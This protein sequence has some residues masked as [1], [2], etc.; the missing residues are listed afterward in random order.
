MQQLLSY[1]L[2]GACVIRLLPLTVEFATSKMVPLTAAERK[3]LNFKLSLN[4]VVFFYQCFF[5]N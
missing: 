1:S 4:D 3:Q 5:I 2:S